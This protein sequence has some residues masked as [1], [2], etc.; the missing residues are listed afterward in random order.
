MNIKEKIVDK[1]IDFIFKK[2]FE[3]ITITG[4]TVV[5]IVGYIKG[6]LFYSFKIRVIDCIFFV[7]GLL[8]IYIFYKKLKSKQK[9][10][11]GTQVIL[12]TN[13]HPIMSAG[14]YCFINNK[15]KC[16]WVVDKAI[17]SEYINQN[18]LK[19]YNHVPSKPREIN[20]IWS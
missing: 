5:A 2:T 6:F 13:T 7:I 4:I 12:T 8:V 18:L 3:L 14:K 20:S 10:I 17:K 16:T 1:F 11:E 15:V 19:E 9:F